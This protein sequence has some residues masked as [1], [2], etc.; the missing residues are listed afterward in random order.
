ML[1][2]SVSNTTDIHEI[3]KERGCE[4]QHPTDTQLF[5]DIDTQEDF[6]RFSVRFS[7]LSTLLPD[8]LKSKEILPS[9]QGFPHCHIIINFGRAL[10]QLEQLY[11]QSLLGSDPKREILCAAAWFK[12]ETVHNILF[13]PLAPV[14]AAPLP[15][16]WPEAKD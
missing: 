5:I 13:R 6:E 8:A 15:A 4:V 16:A 2:N 11:F 14:A 12:G 7:H 1:Y 3:A 9:K 10:S